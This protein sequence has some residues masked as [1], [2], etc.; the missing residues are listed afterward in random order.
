M[1]GLTPLSGTRA[2]DRT[3]QR[4]GRLLVLE[5]TDR[6]QGGSVVWRCR[7]DCGRETLVSAKLLASGKIAS[8]NCLRREKAAQHATDHAGKRYGKLLALEPLDKRQGGGVV[9][10]C[11]CDCGN[12][13]LVRGSYL[14]TGEKWCCADCLRKNKK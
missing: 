13:V 6:R 11:R 5:P 2:I 12:E 8:C 7:C 3:G 4:C 10:R 14:V 9:W 1:S